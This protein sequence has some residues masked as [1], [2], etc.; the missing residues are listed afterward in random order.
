MPQ[1][2]HVIYLLGPFSASATRPCE[3]VTEQSRSSH[4]SSPNGAAGYIHLHTE[5]LETCPSH[6]SKLPGVRTPCAHSP[7]ATI[8][9]GVCGY[10][11][12]CMYVRDPLVGGGLIAQFRGFPHPP[13]RTSAATSTCVTVSAPP[14]DRLRRRSAVSGSQQKLRSHLRKGWKQL[15]AH[16]LQGRRRKSSVVPIG[17]VWALRRLRRPVVNVK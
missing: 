6:K 12:H 11:I 2:I 14:G 15:S 9:M 7:F 17:R 16:I 3:A 5:P 10:A 1:V 8:S 13:P 4:A